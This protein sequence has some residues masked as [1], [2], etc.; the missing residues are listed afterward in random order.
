MKMLL[1]LLPK[2]VIETINLSVV[3]I[4]PLKTYLANQL[5]KNTFKY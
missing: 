2:I 1:L 5:K 4:K 3:E